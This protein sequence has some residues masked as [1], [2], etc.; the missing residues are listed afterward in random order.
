MQQQSMKVGQGGAVAID[1]DRLATT[2]SPGSVP[3]SHGRSRN[4]F[5]SSATPPDLPSARLSPRLATTDAAR[6][7]LPTQ[8]ADSLNELDHR[9]R[10]RAGRCAVLDYS[11]INIHL[12]PARLPPMSQNAPFADSPPLD[13]FCAQPSRHI[14]LTV[15][16]V[17]RYPLKTL[18]CGGNNTY[19]STPNLN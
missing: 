18:D 2:M 13:A 17:P 3:R 9:R 7:H 15:L 16:V 10:R 8:T 4:E 1:I 19:V 5:E 14:I 6:T 11:V 12:G